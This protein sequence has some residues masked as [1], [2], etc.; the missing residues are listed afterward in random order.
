[1]V[2]KTTGRV[3]SLLTDEQLGIPLNATPCVLRDDLLAHLSTW[4]LLEITR[5]GRF[6]DIQILQQDDK[7]ENFPLC[8]NAVY[9]ASLETEQVL[10]VTTCNVL[11]RCLHQS[12]LGTINKIVVRLDEQ[13]MENVARENWE[14][15]PFNFT[16]PPI[17]LQTPRDLLSPDCL[18]M[19][20]S[21]AKVQ[22]ARE[23]RE[24]ELLE[25]KEKVRTSTYV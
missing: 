25:W 11:V 17:S 16:L 12:I 22:K 4:M 9:Q 6:I 10:G 5:L 13:I 1:M 20:D 19:I 2:H 14:P 15:V 18:E 23:A 24:L 7:F 8:I 21:N 3:A